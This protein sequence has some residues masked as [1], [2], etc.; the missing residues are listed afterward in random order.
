[1]VTE[2]KQFNSL[3]LTYYYFTVALVQ[4]LLSYSH[5]SLKMLLE[6]NFIRRN[7]LETRSILWRTGSC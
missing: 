5:E 1:M 2:I 3:L 6:K 7:R 4:I